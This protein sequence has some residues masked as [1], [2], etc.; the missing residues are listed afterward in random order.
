MFKTIIYLFFFIFMTNCSKKGLNFPDEAI[1][2]SQV[3]NSNSKNRVRLFSF[4]SV[5]LDSSPE[6]ESI[7]ISNDTQTEN[8]SIF[9]KTGNGWTLIKNFSYPI[10][11][12]K[13]YSYS[14][15][16]KTWTE[17]KETKEPSIIK[18]VLLQE[19]PGTSY[20]SIFFE[21]VSLN[22]D[23]KIHSTL[24]IISNYN[25]IFDGS[26][27][28]KGHPLQD[29]NLRTDFEYLPQDKSVRLFPKDFQ[30]AQEIVYNGWEMIP[31][32]SGLTIPALLESSISKVESSDEYLAKFLFK[33]RGSY[34]R[35]TYLSFYFPDNVTIRFPENA[36]G[37]SFYKKGSS[38]FLNKQK[39]HGASKG[40]LLE[41]TKDEWGSN[42]KYSIEFSILGKNLEKKYLLF[43]SSTKISS[44]IQSIP[45]EFSSIYTEEDGQ[46]F[47]CYKIGFNEK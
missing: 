23:G 9:S 34:N 26:R 20:N 41:I 13:S 32:I 10:P 31:K 45:N 1:I 12:G 5:N 14:E 11:E 40:N 28:L 8:L 29:R 4:K 35:V 2:F 38:V 44:V 39:K 25:L 47:Y 36:K 7:I 6:L 21:V 3:Y 18:R 16:N 37:Y 15:D 30:Y 24:Y 27:F 43:R 17:S 33:N 46:E 42:Y 19:L 22:S